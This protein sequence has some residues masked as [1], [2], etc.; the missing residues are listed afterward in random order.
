MQPGL[1][2]NNCTPNGDG[3]GTTQVGVLTTWLPLSSNTTN[4]DAAIA[5]VNSGAVSPTGA[6]LELGPP[7]EQAACWP[8]RLPASLRRPA[9]AKTPSVN[10]TVAKSGRTTGLTCANISAVNLYVE[11]SYFTNCDETTALPDQ[12]LHQSDRQL[13]R[14]QFSDAGDSGSLVV[15]ASDAEPVGLFFAGGSDTQA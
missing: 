15:D 8:P 6:I 1:I 14:N 2:D 13:K 11:V 3:A 10:M 4:A 5:Q 9:R 12:D 7:Q